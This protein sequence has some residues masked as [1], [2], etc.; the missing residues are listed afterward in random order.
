MIHGIW[1]LVDHVVV[2]QAKY[3]VLKQ[4]VQQQNVDQMKL[5]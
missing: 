3:D 5:L 2:I 1:M 4:N